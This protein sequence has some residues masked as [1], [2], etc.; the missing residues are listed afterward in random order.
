MLSF[1]RWV[2]RYFFCA[3]LLKILQNGTFR[4]GRGHFR[5]ALEVKIFQKGLVIK[6]RLLSPAGIIRG[7]EIFLFFWSAGLITTMKSALSWS[8]RL[9]IEYPL[10]IPHRS[11]EGNIIA[12]ILLI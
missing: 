3:K 7:S 8:K 4:K 5:F 1:S 11:Y 10:L 2:R 9:A 12:D 6:N